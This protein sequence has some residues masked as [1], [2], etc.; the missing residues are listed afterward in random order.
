MAPVIN[1]ASFTIPVKRTKYAV[2]QQ[3]KQ[4]PAREQSTMSDSLKEKKKGKA[5]KETEKISTAYFNIKIDI[6]LDT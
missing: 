3:Q 1:V 6:C 4:N 5:S 2:V